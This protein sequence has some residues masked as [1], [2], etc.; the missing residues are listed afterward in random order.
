[1][2]NILVIL[3]LFI[4]IECFAFCPAPIYINDE[5]WAEAQ[6]SYHECVRQEQRQRE[7][8]RRQKETE[9]RLRELEEQNRRSNGN[10]SIFNRDDSFFKKRY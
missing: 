9:R 4:S 8:E 3:F 1:M 2:R 6:Y 7:L 5:Q 10:D